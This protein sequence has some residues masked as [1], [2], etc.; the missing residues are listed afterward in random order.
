MV[1]RNRRRAT[2]PS[3]RA[4][5]PFPRPTRFLDRYGEAG[6]RTRRWK[7]PRVHTVEEL[8]DR[9]S[10]PRPDLVED[11][12]R[13]DGTLVV[14]GAAG[15]LGP[16]LVRLAVRAAAE[17][18]TGMRVVAVSRFGTPGS[19][20]ALREAGAEVVV[21]D[22]ADEAALAALPDA[23]HVVFLVGAKF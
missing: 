10:R 19:A 8:E 12:R 2:V 4:V 22:L 18:G 20:E 6:T 15:K 14:L 13:L 5:R 16:S 21:A 23:D 17:A 3:R 11:M 7:E 9:L 1:S